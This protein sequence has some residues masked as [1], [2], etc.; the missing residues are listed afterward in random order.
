MVD[1]DIQNIDAQLDAG[2]SIAQSIICESWD[3]TF[4]RFSSLTSAASPRWGGF[5]AT[6]LGVPENLRHHVE[7]QS[8]DMLRQL[9]PDDERYLEIPPEYGAAWPLDFDERT[10]RNIAGSF[11]YPSVMY[12]VIDRRSGAPYALRRVDGARASP[13]VI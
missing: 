9:E 11:G 8:H 13:K 12:K 3:Q 6:S 10:T 2:E 5:R 4:I 1:P 7:S